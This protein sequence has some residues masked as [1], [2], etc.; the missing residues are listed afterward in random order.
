MNEKAKDMNGK[1]TPG[2]AILKEDYGLSLADNMVKDSP[3]SLEKVREA[4]L[5]R[6]AGLAPWPDTD[7]DA[8]FESPETIERDV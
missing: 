7:L 3:V 1:M 2:A 6:F 4:N 5:K 8:Y